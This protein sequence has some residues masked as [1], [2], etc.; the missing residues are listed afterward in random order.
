M[1]DNSSSARALPTHER[2]PEPVT[3]FQQE[4]T[5]NGS[6]IRILNGKKWEFISGVTS[7]RL[8]YLP[9]MLSNLTQRKGSTT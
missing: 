1:S 7:S 3:E 9:V 4:R 6:R 8:T 2:T 5:S